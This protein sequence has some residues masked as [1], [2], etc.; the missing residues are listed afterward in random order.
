MVLCL[1]VASTPALAQ[2]KTAEELARIRAASRYE[3]LVWPRPTWSLA[4]KA[5]LSVGDV[6]AT[7]TL[8]MDLAYA[9]GAFDKRLSFALDAAWKP[10]SVDGSL[11]TY[12]VQVE[13]I[14]A[15]A[16]AFWH[17]YSATSAI[18]P[19]VGAGLG[20]VARH[21]ATTFPGPGTR[22]ER[23]VAPAGFAALGLAFRVGPGSFEAEVRARYSPSQTV[24]LNGSSNSPYS[25]TAGYRFTLR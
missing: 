4:P 1:L 3:G 16:G 8:G 20:V 9:P 18:A 14:S 17:A 7:Y 25:L 15:S 22:N 5:G 21:A 11:G 23:E 19:F 6:G 24:V 13:E 12:Q 2:Q 10:S